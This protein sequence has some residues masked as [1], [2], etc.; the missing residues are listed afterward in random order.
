MECQVNTQ[1]V[2]DAIDL[3]QIVTLVSH[4]YVK[5]LRHGIYEHENCAKTISDWVR[6]QLGCHF[7]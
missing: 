1:S 7:N 2:P 5:S 6:S 3:S 4:S